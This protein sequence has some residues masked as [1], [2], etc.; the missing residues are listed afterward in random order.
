METFVGVVL[1]TCLSVVTPDQTIILGARQ[2]MMFRAS[3][4]EWLE[5]TSNT[6]S[7]PP[8][9]HPAIQTLSQSTQAEP[10]LPLY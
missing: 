1:C 2:H 9:Q 6:K 5:V 7:V 3:E 10:K 4:I 8:I